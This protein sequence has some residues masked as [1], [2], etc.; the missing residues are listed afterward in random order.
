MS[1]ATKIKYIVIHCTAGHTPAQK[2]QDYFLRPKSKGGRGWNTGGYHM[3]IE[4]DGT[5]EVMYDFE[6]ITNGVEGFNEECIHISYVGGVNP[7]NVNQ[8]QD[9]RTDAQKRSLHSTIQIAI[10]WLKLHG[11]DITRDLKVLGHYDFSIDKNR[12]GIIDPQERI[13]A[14]PSFEVK[15]E[16]GYLY[17]SPDTYS[18]LPHGVR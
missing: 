11:K 6:K 2:V 9:T 14:C 3:I 13:K 18:K 12:N 1:R 10:K 17:S 15:K 16:Y 7:Q 4:K 8:E 5:V